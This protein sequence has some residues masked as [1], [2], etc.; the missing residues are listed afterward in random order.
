MTSSLPSRA[1]RATPFCSFS[2]R[3]VVAMNAA[4]KGAGRVTAEG[5]AHGN[6]G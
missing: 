3:G 5:T 6:C 1:T 2:A 4:F